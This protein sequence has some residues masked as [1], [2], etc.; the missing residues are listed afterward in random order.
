MD[1]FQ[2][3]KARVAVVPKKKRENAQGGA[4]S[5]D[6]VVT[7]AVVPKRFNEQDLLQYAFMI[8]CLHPGTKRVDTSEMS[9][10]C[11]WRARSTG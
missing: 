6:T 2:A 9:L 3:A 8:S 1:I 7:E 10:L 11:L 5:L 4:S